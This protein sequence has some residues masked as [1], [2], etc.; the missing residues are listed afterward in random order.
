MEVEAD[1]M[2]RVLLA[3]AAT[4]NDTY[5]LHSGMWGARSMEILKAW[6]VTKGAAN[7]TVLMT[8]TGTDLTHEDL[9]NQLWTNAGESQN[10]LDDDANGFV[11][12]IYGAR[13][14]RCVLN[15]YLG[16]SSYACSLSSILHIPPHAP[17]PTVTHL[18][19]VT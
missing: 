2:P 4:P 6:G 18:A 9:R 19:T 11:D 16:G 14:T 8:D 3:D 15:L 17:N 12:D 1:A 7:V 5:F 10:G 13:I